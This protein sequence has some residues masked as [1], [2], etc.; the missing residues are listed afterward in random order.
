[1]ETKQKYCALRKVCHW[2]VEESRAT[3]STTPAALQ[4]RQT[5]RQKVIF[6]MT[7]GHF[8]GFDIFE[9]RMKRYNIK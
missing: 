2:F 7:I 9:N 5:A 3:T 8:V 4:K 6:K 1:L